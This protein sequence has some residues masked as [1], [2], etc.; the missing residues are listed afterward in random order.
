MNAVRSV[1][2]RTWASPTAIPVV[3]VSMGAAY[4]G[5][6]LAAEGLGAS[7]GFVDE[8]RAGSLL[9]AGA[10]ALSLAEPLEVG[11]DARRGMLSLRVAKGGGL[12]LAQRWLALGLAILPSVVA[13]AWASG[14]LPAAPVA[15]GLQLLV[16]C[17][18]GML[19]GAWFE[20]Q[21]LVPGLWLL[22]VV[23]HL[24]PWLAEVLPPAA[25]LLPRLGDLEGLSGALHALLWCAGALLLAAARLRVLLGRGG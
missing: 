4:L 7:G 6:R 1:L 2:V 22:L 15:L 10:L 19:L 13:A 20:R 9:F 12:A 11:R 24:R 5:T 14:S 8:V 16:L 21:L 23:A 18:G 17:A 25:W 3:L